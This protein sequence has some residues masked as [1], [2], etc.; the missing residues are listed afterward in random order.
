MNDKKVENLFI[1]QC[2]LLTATYIGSMNIVNKLL[3]LNVPLTF[4]SDNTPLVLLIAKYNLDKTTIILREL[5]ELSLNKKIEVYDKFIQAAFNFHLFA[6]YL[7]YGYK[8]QEISSKKIFDFNNTLKVAQWCLLYAIK[9]NIQSESLVENFFNI[10][11]SLKTE[12]NIPLLFI[13]IEND[14]KTSEVVLDKL[15]EKSIK[16]GINLRTDFNK[17]SNKLFFKEE[18]KFIKHVLLISIKQDYKLLVEKILFNY[19]INWALFEHKE[20]FNYLVK[21]LSDVPYYFKK[22]EKN[23]KKIYKS[24]TLE[25]FIEFSVDKIDIN[26]KVVENLLISLV[27]EYEDLN[28]IIKLLNNINIIANLNKFILTKLLNSLFKHDEFKELLTISPCS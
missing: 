2:L 5:I 22:Y 28:I 3:E 11:V 18:T 23:S 7:K 13:I 19:N 26:A 24:L 25:F 15:I 20:N 21:T 27:N 10:N 16:Q 17:F 6:H 9:F 8:N 1:G 12:K 14:M 4:N